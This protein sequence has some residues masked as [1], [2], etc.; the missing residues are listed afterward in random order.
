MKILV[1]GGYGFIGSNLVMELN[2]RYPDAEIHVMDKLTYAA[3]DK[4]LSKI[5]NGKN[6]I[7]TFIKDICDIIALDNYDYIY[8]LAA[9]SHVDKSIE[10]PNIFIRTNVSGTQNLLELARRDCTNLKK[11][12]HVSTDEVYGD[13]PFD[14]FLDERFTENSPLKPSS[15][16]SASKAASDLIALS[17]QK[18]YGLPVVV[19]RSSNNIGPRQ[20]QSKLIPKIIDCIINNK[21]LTLYNNGINERDWLWVYDHV[22]GLI[23]AAEKGTIGETY[24]FGTGVSTPNITI[25]R[26]LEEIIGKECYIKH[27]EDRKGH[28][29]IY[30]CDY[31]KAEKELGWR[32]STDLETALKKTVSWYM[33]NAT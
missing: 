8:H 10:G 24:L 28:D 33:K 19:T 20:D 27:V 6:K 18:T 26:M 16:Y 1:T 25:I 22:D 5:N 30:R 31:T 23:K 32:P 12:V 3:N 15:P 4:N 17:Y 11:F 9:E 29:A 7:N 21:E 13:I 2:R 14:A